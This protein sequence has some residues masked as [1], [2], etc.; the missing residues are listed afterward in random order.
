LLQNCPNLKILVTSREAFGITGEALYPV[1][2]LVLPDLQQVLERILEYESVQLFEER[3]GLVQQHFSLTIENVASIAQICQRLDGIPLAIE[4]AA[5]RVAQ[6]SPQQIA[7]RLNESFNLLTGGSRTALPR[8]QTIRASIEW[9][10]NLLSDAERILL[11][12]L[13]V[14]SGGWT[15]EGAEA[16]GANLGESA[17]FDL[18]NSL[19]EKSLVLVQSGNERYRMLE[20]VRE[21]ALERLRESGEEEQTRNLHLDFFVIMAEEAEPNLFGKEQGLWM[22]KL[23]EEQENILAANDWCARSKGYM[24]ACPNWVSGFSPRHWQ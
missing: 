15:L 17:V 8:Q 6:L 3:A 12:R 9:S 10:W 24:P 21:Y 11:R 23:G 14:F 22:K 13:S 1:P 7:E 4:L 19:V 20:T 5:A 16:V 18:I 2:S